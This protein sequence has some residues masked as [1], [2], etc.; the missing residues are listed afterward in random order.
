V[1]LLLWLMMVMLRLVV[2]VLM[3]LLLLILGWAVELR[4]MTVGGHVS[5]GRGSLCL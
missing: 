1:V 4:M 2:V 3:L 5:E